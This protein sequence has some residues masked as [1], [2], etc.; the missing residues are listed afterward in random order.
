MKFLKS[1]EGILEWIDFENL[2]NIKQFGQNEKFTDCLFT[3]KLFEGKFLL[4]ANCKAINYKI[5]YI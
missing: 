2:S 5:R 1:E 3:D 4:D